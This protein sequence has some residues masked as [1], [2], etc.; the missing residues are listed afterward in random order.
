MRSTEQLRNL[1]KLSH[2][3]SSAPTSEPSDCPCSRSAFDTSSATL[4]LPTKGAAPRT[5]RTQPVACAFVPRLHHLG[6][7][8]APVRAGS[9]NDE[10]IW[11]GIHLCINGIA[12]GLRST[13]RA[14]DILPNQQ[15]GLGDLFSPSPEILV[16]RDGSFSKAHHTGGVSEP[17]QLTAVDVFTGLR[18]RGS[19]Y[20]CHGARHSPA[21]IA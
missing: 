15:R 13:G 20:A 7:T 6:R 14:S 2:L 11:D 12:A 3:A 8:F 18:Q 4:L 1:V 5:P 9:K 19:V 16:I 17:R 10:C 21:L